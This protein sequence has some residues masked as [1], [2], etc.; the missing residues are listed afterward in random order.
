MP[1]LSHLAPPA[2]PAITMQTALQN[3]IIISDVPGPTGGIMLKSATGATLI[4]NDTGIYI[5][6]GKGAIDHDDRA[7]R[8][9]QRRRA[10]GDLDAADHSFTSAR[11]RSVPTPEPV[12][13]ISSDPRVLVS[14]MPVATMADQYMVAGCA[15]TISGVPT[16][17]LKVLWLT[18]ATR[19]L[20]NGIPPITALSTGLTIAAGAPGGPPIIV[21]TQPRVSA[22]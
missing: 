2:I 7:D 12:T 17:C 15:F 14:G 11:S 20:V 22:L 3:G 16:P 10:D 19:V 13:T 8:D 9:R 1:L 5:Q 21:Q 18:S 6:N 4:V